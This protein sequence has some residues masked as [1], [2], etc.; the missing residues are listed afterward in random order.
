M[1]SESG[2]AGFAILTLDGYRFLYP[3][4]LEWV[5][6][7]W[8]ERG[9]GFSTEV[10]DYLALEARVLECHGFQR[11]SVS[12]TRRFD[13]TGELL[14]RFPLEA[15]FTIVDMAAPPDLPADPR[16]D[17]TTRRANATT[18]RA[19]ASCAIMPS[20]TRSPPRKSCAASCCSTTTA[21]TAPSTIPKPT[22]A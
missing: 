11:K 16:A 17:A 13:L 7:T 6:E 22:C 18:C 3:E 15:G 12:Y 20:A 4:M 14:P 19:S 21:S 10:S 1:V 2:D 8:R 5:L 9:P